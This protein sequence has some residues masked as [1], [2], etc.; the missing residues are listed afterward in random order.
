MAFASSLSSHIGETPPYSTT[1][2]LRPRPPRFGRKGE[3]NGPAAAD[4]DV[5]IQSS[6]DNDGTVEG[7]SG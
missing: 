4:K 7:V 2:A 6:H 1:I 5:S 3:P